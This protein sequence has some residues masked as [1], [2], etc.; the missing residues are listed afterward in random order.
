MREGLCRI[1]SED[2]LNLHKNYLKDLKLKYSVWEKSIPEISGKGI[3]EISRMRIKE[4]EEI[5]ALLLEI[6]CHD[7]YF[8]S[9]GKEYQRSFEV[10]KRFR[11]EA[12]FLYELYE[13]SKNESEG[14]L[15]IYFNR[16]LVDYTFANK[17]SILRCEPILALDLC[18]HSFF[19]DFG[20][21]R[22]SYLKK[23]LSLIN[24]NSLDNFL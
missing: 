3:R 20:F 4:K 9:F 8:S 18:E 23:S 7:V 24:L 16:G 22:D 12:S 10:K 13:A 5:Q 14:F 17:G 15:L 19:L 21:D 6:L 11:T 2:T 1:L